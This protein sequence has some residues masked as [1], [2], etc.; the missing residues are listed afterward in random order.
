[1]KIKYK[2]LEVKYDFLK[3]PKDILIA[4]IVFTAFQ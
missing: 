2:T 4:Y 1:M 3:M